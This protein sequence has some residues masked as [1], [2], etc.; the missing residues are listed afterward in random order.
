M[1]GNGRC[2]AAIPDFY[3]SI[4]LSTPSFPRRTGI[5]TADAVGS[6]AR[7][8]HPSLF[9]L[10]TCKGR[11]ALKFRLA[12]AAL[13]RV[14]PH[15]SF[16]HQGGRDL[17]LVILAWFRA[18]DDVRQLL[19]SRLRGDE[20]YPFRGRDLL[21]GCVLY[22]II[23]GFPALFFAN[24]FREGFGGRCFPSPHTRVL[25]RSPFGERGEAWTEREIGLIVERGL[26]FHIENYALVAAAL[27]GIETESQSPGPGAFR[28]LAS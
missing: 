16:P 26:A 17:S 8:S 13:A 18:T 1:G 27:R 6:G 9:T 22:P 3:P 23:S 4:S 24:R 2:C 7:H 5:Q 14:T 15:P 12:R 20:P 28:R 25:P 11:F 19:D 21:L 10:R